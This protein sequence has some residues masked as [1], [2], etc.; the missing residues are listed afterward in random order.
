LIVRV[1]PGFPDILARW[2]FPV[3]RFIRED[4]P[5][6]ERP[7]NPNSGSNGLGHCFKEVL[8]RT[9]EA[10]WIIMTDILI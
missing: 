4:F 8:L 6:F 9:N 5:T 7:I 2:E 1:F 10:E 3:R